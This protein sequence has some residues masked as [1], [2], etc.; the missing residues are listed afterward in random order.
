M[1]NSDIDGL[2]NSLKTCYEAPADSLG[3]D[4]IKPCLGK[5]KLYK[6]ETAWFRSSA[7]RVWGED[8][9][10][11]LKNNDAKIEIIAFP[12]ID[13]TTKR[14]LDNT[15]DA[16]KKNS[17]VSMHRERILL[18][19]LG[20]EA[21]SNI[22][23]HE[24]GVAIGETLSFLIA[25]GKLEIRFATCINYD[26]YEVVEDDQDEGKLTHVKRGYF[27]FEATET[28][29]E[30]TIVSFCG[31]ANESHAGLMSQGEVFDVFNS[32]NDNHKFKVDEHVERVDNTWNGLREGYKIEE[33][34]RDV[35]DR[36]KVFSN[37]RN[38]TQG[39]KPKL[40][41]ASD[42]K[43][44]DKFWDHKKEA[45]E[46]FLKKEKGILEMATGTGK[47]S[48]A[49]EIARQLILTKKINKVV[50]CP[51]IKKDLNSQWYEEVMQW[52]R[53]FELD[54]LITTRVYRHFSE[55]N[56]SQEFVSRE[57][58]GAALV[59]VQRDAKKLEFIL[60]NVDIEKTLVI[61]DEVHGFAMP[62]VQKI[63][64][65][66]KSFK[67]TLGLSAT[68]DRKFDEEGTKF[69]LDEI[70]EVVFEFPIEAAIKKGILCPFKYYP[71]KVALSDDDKIDI[72]A[73]YSR[74]EAKKQENPNFPKESLYID[75]SKVYGNAENKKFAFK[76]FL[77]EN[78][79]LIK[80]TIIFCQS[81]AQA[82]TL[83]E[84]IMKYTSRF[85]YYF[86]K[87]SDRN[88][89]ERIGKDLDCLISCHILSEGIDIPTL[90][91]IFLMASPS[92]K[93]E[94]IQRIGRCIRTVGSNPNKVANV[95]DFILYRDISFNDC[96]ESNQERLDWLQEVSK[97]RKE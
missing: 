93:L 92:A 78:P 85:G 55:H 9:V 88:Q 65:L 18:K 8:L 81:K 13:K 39:K 14:S 74:Y 51:S 66:H 54:K 10:N 64:G 4:F 24:T 2:M 69:I 76:D 97:T 79:E 50:I 23:N 61:Q 3:G 7:F 53:K 70:G 73:A 15:L 77:E 11:I 20:I 32:R 33:V 19:V 67:Y 63:Q 12:Q 56:D 16:S 59:I 52:K 42:I 41:E 28:Y 44:P 72:K 58:V 5:C 46:I 84:F 96:I 36:I 49:L 57:G 91:N 94:T 30:K 40:K 34:S 83:G 48:T 45:I 82:K 29:Q 31:S 95:V 71:R 37:S 22:H 62:S 35:L 90:N 1:S 43:T 17:I 87:G 6:R 47:T 75:I 38:Q 68:P 21:N 25:S 26:D 89:L 60:S 86:D 27:V 80:N